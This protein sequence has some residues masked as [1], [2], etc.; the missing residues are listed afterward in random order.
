MELELILESLW[1]KSRFT[2]YFYQGVDLT[3]EASIPTLALGL[4][5]S[6][7]TLFY[8]RNFIS[9]L[10]A[11]ELT[12][13][14]IHEMLHIVLNHDHRGFTDGDIFL[15]NL[16]QD[17]VINSY[18]SEH[19][20]TF[21]SR[22]NQYAGE[23]PEIILPKG[24][25]VIPEKFFKETSISD[26]VWEE[27]YRWLK[28]QNDD[29]IKN[30]KFNESENRQTGI[31]L[32][33]KSGIDLLSENLANLDL[34]YNT[35]PKETYTG[36]KNM[37]GLMFNKNDGE[38]IPTGIHIMNK[39]TD[40]NLLDSKM[41]HF[42]TVAKKD[43]ICTNERVFNDITS[44][45]NAPQKTDLS[46]TEKLKSIVDITSQSNEWE[47]SYHRF[48]KRYFSQGIYAPGRSFKDKE[49]ITVIVDV[50]GSMVMKPGDIE[51][52]FG[53]IEGL[54][55]KFKIYLLC[56]DEN[57]FI[58]EKKDNSFLRSDK[59]SKP[60]EYRKGDWKYLKTGS[61][62]T[63]YFAPLFNSY[64]ENHNELLIVI[65]DGYIYDIDHLKKYSNTLWLIS[66]HRDEPFKPPF[67]RSIKISSAAPERRLKIAGGYK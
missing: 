1:E 64:M 32:A 58:P 2:S 11:D 9:T 50:S 30:F 51:S 40:L 55:A 47:Y 26:P 57:L 13:L 22:T 65:S 36:F 62:G 27:I 54:L 8:N 63:T 56:I 24:L 3:E 10:T 25:P 39:K 49:A 42:M 17:M 41:N 37:T 20:K 52:A 19:R 59:N 61:S 15:Q 44:L 46:W 18:I 48:N 31:E 35:A 4:Y 67:G 14:L 29:D 43:D 38:H 16:A 21:F 45:I 12:G 6:R 34:S 7:L 66:E 5:S 23:I 33:G 60:Y 28:C 53:I